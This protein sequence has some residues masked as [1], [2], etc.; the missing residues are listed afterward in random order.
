MNEE[1]LIIRYA[2]ID[3][4]ESISFLEK[5]ALREWGIE[6][7][8]PDTE[9]NEFY[10]SQINYNLILVA[11]IND[12]VIG[13]SAFT[14]S[15][16]SGKLE[17]GRLHITNTVIHPDFRR[18]GIAGKIRKKI[19]EICSER[20]FKRIT[21]NHHPDNK[22]IINLSKKLGFKEYREPMVDDS[23]RND[24]FMELNLQP[25]TGPTIFHN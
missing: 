25:E 5:T 1:N 13:Y 4:L 17:E 24:I 19:I 12:K 15:R 22:A 23:C 11:S 20:N 10:I 6:C 9:V 14:D 7:G 3:D 21:T 2:V 18:R 8:L 16:L